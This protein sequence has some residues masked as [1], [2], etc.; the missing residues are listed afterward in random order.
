MGEVGFWQIEDAVAL[1]HDSCLSCDASAFD[2]AVVGC[3]F[4]GGSLGCV[5]TACCTLHPSR[6]VEGEDI[7]CCSFLDADG[8][9]AR[10]AHD[11]VLSIERTADGAAILHL[12]AVGHDEWWRS[13]GDV[14]HLTQVIAGVR[15]LVV[16]THLP[17]HRIAILM[18]VPEGVVA[19]LRRC[20]R[21][22]D[23]DTVV[24]C[25]HDDFLAPV[26]KDVA[27]IARGALR[28]VVSHGTSTCVDRCP[29]TIFR[30]AS[31]GVL[32][33]EIVESLRTKVA[34]PIDAEVG[35]YTCGGESI[36]W[37]VIHQ[38]D[39]TFACRACESSREVVA[40]I[41][42]H[43]TTIVVA[44]IVTVINL[45][46]GGIAVVIAWL[47]LVAGIDFLS[48]DIRIEVAAMLCVAMS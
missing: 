12:L 22:I 15:R 34:I 8:A 38:T 7:R 31:L 11:D 18:V 16:A 10:F 19:I 48:V 39:G 29:T 35:V 2:V 26:P 46:G 25:A 6:N 9:V 43:G 1:L 24:G 23:A 41:T 40:E 28:V 13:N 32:S 45:A 30:H 33:V 21:G 36:D 47:I 42:C 3:I 5:F 4:N 44:S 14:F 27:L 37:V 17:H 20:R